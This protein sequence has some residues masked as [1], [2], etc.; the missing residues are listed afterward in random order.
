MCQ[1]F[2]IYIYV[3]IPII[4]PCFCRDPSDF[5]RRCL[6]AATSSSVGRCRICAPPRRCASYKH[7]DFGEGL[8]HCFSW[9]FMMIYWDLLV[10]DWW[11][12]YSWLDLMGFRVATLY[13]LVVGCPKTWENVVFWNMFYCSIIYGNNDPSWLS[14]FSEG[15]KLLN[16]QTVYVLSTITSNL[17]MNLYACI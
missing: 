13:W 7:G 10:I 8:L 4:K 2:T 14:Y 16:H 9:E 12:M 3:N 5:S 17:Y 1:L 15:L 11:F 6:R